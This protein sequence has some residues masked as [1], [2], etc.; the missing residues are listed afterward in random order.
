MSTVELMK[1]L[2]DAEET[3]RKIAA[4]EQGELRYC[5]EPMSASDAREYFDRHPERKR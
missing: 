2:E 5:D 4:Y 3:L 1:R